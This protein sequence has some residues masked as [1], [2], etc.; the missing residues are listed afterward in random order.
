M[1]IGNCLLIIR[2]SGKESIYVSSLPVPTMQTEDY[3][4]YCVSHKISIKHLYAA[5]YSVLI[6]IYNY[7][8]NADNII[9]Y[10]KGLL[11]RQMVR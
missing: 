5:D 3:K 11:C 4:L 1:D 9:V 8:Y 10:M 2:C 7:V 6:S